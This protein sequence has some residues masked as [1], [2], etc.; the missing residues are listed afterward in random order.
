MPREVGARTTPQAKAAGTSKPRATPTPTPTATG[1]PLPTT[2]AP[3][4]C[5]PGRA[6][7]GRVG[8]G[9]RGGAG[10]P[11]V[12]GAHPEADLEEH[13][14]VD[15]EAGLDD[16]EPEADLPGEHHHRAP[17]RGPE[18]VGDLRPQEAPGDNLP[19][20]GGPP[21][22]HGRPPQ[23]PGRGEEAEEG[24]EL[25][26]RE[27]LVEDLLPVDED[28]EACVP[29]EGRL[30]GALPPAVAG[31]ARPGRGR[32]AVPP[33]SKSPLSPSARRTRD[34]KPLIPGMTGV[35]RYSRGSAQGPGPRCTGTTGT[36]SATG[37]PEAVYCD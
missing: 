21:E 30:S 22:A 27:G 10:G 3:K 17:L 11:A 14:D 20:E 19:R 36:E 29:R 13:R 26:V 8:G 16:E 37:D 31:A 12:P 18:D 5:G 7:R 23:E 24:H 33:G 2:A 25:P 9:P 1:S 28:L 35:S 15:L 4:A 6:G 34:R 32:R